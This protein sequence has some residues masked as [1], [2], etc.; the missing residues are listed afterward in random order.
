VVPWRMFLC[1]VIGVRFPLSYASLGQTGQS[2]RLVAANPGVHGLA[3]RRTPKRPALSEHPRALAERPIPV[4]G[5]T[6]P[7]TT[8][9]LITHRR[10][11]NQTVDHILK[12]VKDV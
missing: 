8:R 9:Q 6:I 12:T 4:L 2:S 5:H 3:R 7:G 10:A 1:L 11:S